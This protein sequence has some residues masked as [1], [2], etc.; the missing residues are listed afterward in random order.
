MMPPAPAAAA[1]NQPHGLSAVPPVGS[2]GS[3]LLPGGGTGGV[4]ELLSVAASGGGVAATVSAAANGFF[5]EVEAALLVRSCLEV[6]A[7]GGGAEFSAGALLCAHDVS[8]SCDF[9]NAFL[10]G[11]FVLPSAPPK[12][13]SMASSCSEYGRMSLDTRMLMN[14]WQQPLAMRKPPT[15]RGPMCPT[16]RSMVPR[17][18]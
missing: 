16:A 12:R 4:G 1:R 2:T 13:P 15:M 3:A 5:F 7:A 11:A 8:G 6:E 18:T 10:V 14:S 17:K 9:P